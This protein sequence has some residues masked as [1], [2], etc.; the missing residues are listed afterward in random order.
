MEDK[1]VTSCA[2][3]LLGSWVSRFGIPDHITSDRGG[4]FVSR[5]CYVYNTLSISINLSIK[6]LDVET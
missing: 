3:A 5:L 1:T 4:Q 2:S 6:S